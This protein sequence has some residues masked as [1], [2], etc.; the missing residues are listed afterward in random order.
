MHYLIVLEISAP[1]SFSFWRNSYSLAAALMKTSYR[2]LGIRR[3]TGREQ[4]ATDL[5][6]VPSPMT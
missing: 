4:N 2:S 5:F 6:R 1:E 3:M